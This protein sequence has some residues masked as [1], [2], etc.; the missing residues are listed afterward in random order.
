MNSVVELFVAVDDFWLVFRPVWHQ[1]LLASGERQRI[2]PARL[3]ESE[4]MTIVILFHQS[5]YRNFKAFYLGYVRRHLKGEFPHLVSYPRFVALMQ[6]MGLPL[7]VFLRISMGRCTGISF[8]DSTPLAV[9]HNKR[10][11]R[12]RVFDGFAERGKTSMGWFYG[13]KLHLMIN[14]HGEIIAFALTPGN[15][16][17]RVPLPRMRQHVFGKLFGDKGYLSQ[18]LRDDLREVGVELITSIRRNMKPQL[19][20]L[21]DK[22]LLKRRSIIE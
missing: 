17:D 1:H 6:S 22:L 13:F 19:L 12:H 8:I 16:D 20:P 9:C 18:T 10:I 3:S 21:Y 2:R 5:Q 15:V 4:I 14:H 7:Y 11:K